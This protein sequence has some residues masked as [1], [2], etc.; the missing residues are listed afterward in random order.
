MPFRLVGFALLI[1]AGY[2]LCS[3]E[4]GKTRNWFKT[5]MTGAGI[6]LFFAVGALITMGRPTCD[7][8]QDDGYR[9]ST[10]LE[11]A[12]DGY[13][14]TYQQRFERFFTVF[15]IM[16]AAG[17]VSMLIYFRNNKRQGK[18]LGNLDWQE[19]YLINKNWVLRQQETKNFLD[20]SEEYQKKLLLQGYEKDIIASYIEDYSLSK[21]Q[22]QKD[23]LSIKE[24]V[25]SVDNVILDNQK[26]FDKDYPV[27]LLVEQYNKSIKESELVKKN[28]LDQ[29]KRFDK[30]Y[31][32]ELIVEQLEKSRKEFSNDWV[33]EKFK[34]DPFWVY[35][36]IDIN[37]RKNSEDCNK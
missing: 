3:S 37:R 7:D 8:Y 31:P 22:F 18:K 19:Q 26:R 35:N 28:I 15:G 32:V 29:H 16:T 27:G 17:S 13:I 1:W 14:A 20:D 23:P 12:D 34:N 30:I 9:G 21:E 4:Y 10:C 2:S 11:Y 33:A 36:Q 24:L 6:S 5:W 25:E